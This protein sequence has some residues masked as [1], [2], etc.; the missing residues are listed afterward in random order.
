MT[1]PPPIPAQTGRPCQP[2][3]THLSTL[4]SFISDAI[5]DVR[6]HARELENNGASEMSTGRGMVVPWVAR[7]ARQERRYPQPDDGYN[8]PYRGTTPPPCP[9]LVTPV[10]FN[11]HGS[12]ELGE[13]LRQYG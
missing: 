5:D 1:T 13:F 8:T 9:G 4:D 6:I 11:N 3:P 12:R 10:R 2:P 7:Q